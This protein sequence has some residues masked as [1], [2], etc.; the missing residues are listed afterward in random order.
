MKPYPIVKKKLKHPKVRSLTFW[1]FR[2]VILLGGNS[3]EKA[4]DFL[5]S[6]DPSMF[7]GSGVWLLFS[8]PEEVVQARQADIK[9]IAKDWFS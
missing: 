9:S 7:E 4:V 1:A 8:N 2:I 6:P 3:H 5:E